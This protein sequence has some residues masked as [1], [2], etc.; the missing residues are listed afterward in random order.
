MD[1]LSVGPSLPLT[2]SQPTVWVVV[3]RELFAQAEVLLACGMEALVLSFRQA[4]SPQH[5]RHHCAVRPSRAI[6]LAPRR[7]ETNTA[8]YR[9]FWA[10]SSPVLCSFDWIPSWTSVSHSH[11]GTFCFFK[12]D[13]SF[14]TK[15][16]S[17]SSLTLVFQKNFSYLSIIFRIFIS[18]FIFHFRAEF[19]KSYRYLYIAVVRNKFSFWHCSN[20]LKNP[21]DH[22]SNYIYV[23]K[24]YSG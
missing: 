19:C 12:V 13:W 18:N 24:G 9:L 1:R 17:H 4:P 16:S 21:V 6:P 22:L 20:F 8:F 23:R 10:V 7:L 11:R 3:T 14:E 2:S 15:L 5:A